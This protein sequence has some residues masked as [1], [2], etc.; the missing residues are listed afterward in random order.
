M[1]VVANNW[2]GTDAESVYGDEVRDMLRA[3]VEGSEEESIG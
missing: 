2:L 3:K 1:K